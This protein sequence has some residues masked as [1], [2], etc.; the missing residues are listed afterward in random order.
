MWLNTAGVPCINSFAEA[1]QRFEMTPPIRG[2]KDKVRPLGNRRRYHH[3]AS[4]DM[5]DADTVEFKYYGAPF[6]TWKSDNTFAVTTEG[7][8]MSAY[9]AAHL[10][11]FLPRAMYA[12]WNKCRM[13]VGGGDKYY[14]IN[15]GDRFVFAKDGDK[16]VLT[17]KPVA[18]AIRK[19][20]GADRNILAKCEPFFD[21]LTVV[22]AVNNDFT[23]EETSKSMNVL[24]EQ[25]GLR[26]PQWYQKRLQETYEPSN[27]IDIAERQKVYD[28]YRLIDMVPTSLSRYMHLRYRTFHT[29][30]AERLMQWVESDDPENWVQAMNVL[31]DRAGG[32]RYRH[33]DVKFE[34]QLK[35]AA[36]YL[37]E[38]ARH[39]HRDTI[40][41]KVQLEDGVVP[42][43]CNDVYFR[44]HS[45]AL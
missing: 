44:S 20:R 22:T 1:K 25:S 4:I 38:V 29:P 42:S 7:V 14:L 43:R 5:P 37:T 3:M 40:F 8:Y 26:T 28:D 45:F 9:S 6:V 11:C 32:R 13:T 18:F 35:Q 36:K 10:S 31:A 24:R 2:N 30:T 19:K 39:V 33:G 23:H 34:L 15:R 41:Y 12:Q 27:N 16:F 17:N 21:W